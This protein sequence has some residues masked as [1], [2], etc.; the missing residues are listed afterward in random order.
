M[1]PDVTQRLFARFEAMVRQ[2]KERPVL[3]GMQEALGADVD[4]YEKAYQHGRLVAIG[5][6]ATQLKAL[7]DELIADDEREPRGAGECVC[8]WPLPSMVELLPDPPIEQSEVGLNIR[9]PKCERWFGRTLYSVDVVPR[10][11]A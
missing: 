6:L 4:G 1:N 5:E 8:G 3:E 11:K 10:A 9:C 2:V 7:F